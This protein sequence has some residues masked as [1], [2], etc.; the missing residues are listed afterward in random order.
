MM[1]EVKVS[2]ETYDKMLNVLAQMPYVQIAPLLDEVARNTR[3]VLKEVTT[4]D[5]GD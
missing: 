1:D 5:N 4:E 3:P 2:K